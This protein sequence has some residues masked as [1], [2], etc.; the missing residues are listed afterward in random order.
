MEVLETISG[1][2]N[3]LLPDGTHGKEEVVIEKS[4][5]ERIIELFKAGKKKKVIAR[6]L[7]VGIKTVRKILG[8][9][10]WVPYRRA[11]VKE[12]L[13]GPF[14]EWIGHRAPE[15]EYNGRVLFRELKEKG[16]RGKYDTVRKYLAPLRPATG[17]RQ[18][19][20]RFETLPGQQAQVD[21]GSSQVWFGEE[22]VRIRFFVMT[23]GYSRRMF[24][25]AFP[26]E[27]LGALIEAHEEA[28][29]FFGG[30]TE[31]V[32]YDNPKTMV[33][34]REGAT[35]V[36]NGVF[37]D[38][39]RHWGYSPRFCRPYRPQTKGKVE[40]GVKY[41]KKNFLV[42]RRFRDLAHLNA[43][44]ERWNRE[45]ADTR[46]HGTTGCRPIDRFSEER[47]TPCPLVKPYLQGLPNTR[48]VTREGFVNWKGNRYSVPWSWGPVAVRVSQDD[49]TLI[50]L[51]AN[52]EDVRHALLT[53]ETGQCR[54]DPSH[55]RPEAKN[56]LTSSCSEDLPPQYDPRWEK[57]E[58]A[59][60][61]LALYDLLEEEV[62]R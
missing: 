31:E 5:H 39:A 50:L 37:E 44:L 49:R 20:V 1:K 38:F 3:N 36:L 16:Y 19:T 8:G 17:N 58:V 52:G 2:L 29:H 42:G 59:R 53:G 40:S 30:V 25:R 35:V 4:L 26:N 61:D 43:E 34:K 12:P 48:Q 23:L 22:R 54:L 24:V 45:E 21:W 9:Q 32:L 13:L 56:V 57:E 41:V 33:I 62:L 27:R 51:S 14:Q 10:E 60:R 55:H 7:G 11:S 18:M 15:I 28:F 47:L 46:L 6:L